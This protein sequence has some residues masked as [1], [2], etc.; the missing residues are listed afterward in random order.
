MFKI[1]HV[2]PFIWLAICAL[3][4][5]ACGKATEEP[6]SASP[7]TDASGLLR[8]VPADT[9]YVVGT[10]APPPDEFLDAIEPKVD[11][12]LAA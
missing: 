1:V 10:F 5:A 8:Y 11:R 9:P 12:F 3:G 4:V 6:E 2:R 7:L